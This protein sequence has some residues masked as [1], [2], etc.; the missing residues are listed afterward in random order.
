MKTKLKSLSI[1]LTMAFAFFVMP[2]MAQQRPEKKFDP[3][4]FDAEMEQFIT[5][6]VGLSPQE[7]SQFFPILKEM[8]KK[9]RILFA[10]MRRYS[11]VDVNDDKACCEAIRKRDELEIQM[12]E[13]QQEYHNKFMKV[14]PAGKVMGVIQ[15]EEKFH[16]QAFRSAARHDRGKR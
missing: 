2:L 14:L 8:Q 6:E 16:R 13:I 9:Q 4:R 7:A 15:A 1:A 5:T 3:A 10:E 11:H 12:K